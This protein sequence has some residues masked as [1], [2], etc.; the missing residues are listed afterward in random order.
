MLCLL[1]SPAYAGLQHGKPAHARVR[2]HAASQS[3]VEAGTVMQPS[4][5]GTVTRSVPSHA[6]IASRRK[7]RV[8]VQKIQTSA[9]RSSAFTR[10]RRG[11]SSP[12]IVRAASGAVAHVASGATAAFQCVINALEQVGYPVRFMGGWASS[13]HMRHSLHYQGLALDI[14]QIGRNVTRPQMPANEVALANGCGLTSGAQ[15]RHA[16]SGHFQLTSRGSS[17]GRVAV[18]D[19]RPR[20]CSNRGRHCRSWSRETSRSWYSWRRYSSA[21]P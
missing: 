4:C 5:M 20:H 18:A 13:G 16:D 6:K 10:L 15:W 21:H 11:V 8:P 1:L 12:G 3:C 17:P 19:A 7:T 14:N 2:H 9:I